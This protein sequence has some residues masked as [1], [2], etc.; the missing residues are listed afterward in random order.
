MR[1]WLRY[2]LMT[3]SHTAT[4]HKPFEKQVKNKNFVAFG[5]FV[6]KKNQLPFD[7]ESMFVYNN[8]DSFLTHCFIL[9]LYFQSPLT[10]WSDAFSIWYT[11][12]KRI[13]LQISLLGSI[14]V[15]QEVIELNNTGL[16]ELSVFQNHPMICHVDSIPRRRSI[17]WASRTVTIQFNEKQDHPK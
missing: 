5:N 6:I 10:T 16:I 14:R 17:K 11:L 8:H 2:L 13:Q 9:F 3:I 15:I 7:W 1:V 4:K 12:L